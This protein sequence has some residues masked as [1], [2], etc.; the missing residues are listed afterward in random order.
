MEYITVHEKKVAIT[1]SCDVLVAGGGVAGIAAAL[2]AA[3]QGA[4]VTLVEQQWLLGGLATAGIVTV[5]LPLCDGMGNQQIFGITEELLRLSIKYGHEA[6]YPKAW[7][8][9][10]TFEE[11]RDGQRFLVQFNPQMFALAAEELLLAEGVKILYGAKVTDVQMEDGAI[12]AAVLNTREGDSG[13]ACRAVVDST[14]DA[15]LCVQAGEELY[16]YGAG[17]LNFASL[18]C[19]FSSYGDEGAGYKIFAENYKENRRYDG[20]KADDLSDQMIYVHQ[21]LLSRTFKQREVTGDQ[22]LMPVTMPTIPPIR[23]TRGIKGAYTLDES[24]E[25]VVFADSIGRTTD[26]RKRGPV[27]TVPYRCLYGKTKN[28]LTAGRNIS[29]TEP[30]WDITRCIPTCGV[31]GEAAGIAAAMSAAAGVSVQELDVK[32]LQAKLAANGVKVD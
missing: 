16:L 30:M 10:G 11:K 26:W 29:V 9:G 28:L 13:I 21:Q 4:D 2:S 14:G 8:E 25:G 18:W 22:N 7:L 20:T 5:F 6:R 17:E 19:Y 23:C 24:E 32:Q 3:R 12:R 27:F 31:T 1:R 15:D